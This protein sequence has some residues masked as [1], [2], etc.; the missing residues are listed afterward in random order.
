[1]HCVLHDWPDAECG[2]ILKHLKEAMTP[3]YSKLFINENV[4]PAT[5]ADWEATSLDIIMLSAFCSKERTSQDWG[6]L[7]EKAGLKVVKVWNS[8]NPSE[9]GLIECELACAQ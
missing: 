6:S 7:V 8:S 9:E 5:G 2:T 3:G 1:M 4:I